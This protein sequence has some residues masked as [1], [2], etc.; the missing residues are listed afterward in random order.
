MLGHASCPR[1]FLYH[2]IVH[3]R[4]AEADKAVQDAAVGLCHHFHHRLSVDSPVPFLSCSLYSIELV[5]VATTE[6][7]IFLVRASHGQG[8]QGAK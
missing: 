6:I 3:C 1:S 2:T 7:S 5:D 8:S 4:V